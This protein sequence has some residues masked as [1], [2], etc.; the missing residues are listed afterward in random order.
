MD[1]EPSLRQPFQQP[2]QAVDVTVLGMGASTRPIAELP[3]RKVTGGSRS[4][5][6]Q[7]LVV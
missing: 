4:G 7:Q 3:G 5:R 1:G 6:A 2:G